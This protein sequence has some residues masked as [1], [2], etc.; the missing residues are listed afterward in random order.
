VTSEEAAKFE[1]IAASLVAKY[2]A[3][4]GE[5]AAELGDMAGRVTR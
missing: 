3:E 4:D 5:D 2:G 1:K